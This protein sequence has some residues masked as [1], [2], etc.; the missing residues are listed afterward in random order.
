MNEDIKAYELLARAFVAEGVHTAFAL[1]GDANV[2]CMAAFEKLPGTRVVHARHEHGACAMADGYARATGGVGLASVTCGPG[3]TQ[4]MTA[5]TTSAK[6][7]QPVVVFTG[8]TA[9]SSCHLQSQHTRYGLEGGENCIVGGSYHD[10]LV[11]TP[12]GWRIKHRRL[13]QRW[14][15]GNPIV[16]KF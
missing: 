4:I 9:T 5:L 14:M 6:G 11:R 1:L 10:D 13:E 8:D 2:Q 12:N 3:F 15:D 7:R 16:L